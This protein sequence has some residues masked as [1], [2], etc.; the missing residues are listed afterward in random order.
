ME[1]SPHI[2]NRNNRFMKPRQWDSNCR[3]KTV[4]FFLYQLQ[5]NCVVPTPGATHSSTGPD[6]DCQVASALKAHDPPL[7]FDLESDP[8]ENY[9]LS[10]D[11]EPALHGLLDKILEAKAK[12][13]ASMVFGESQ[14]G[15]GSDPALA[16][17][18]APLCQPKPSCCQCW[19]IGKT[20]PK[21]DLNSG[22]P[23]FRLEQGFQTTEL[24]PSPR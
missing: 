18:C 24:S 9:P 16:P 6:P 20:D 7:V 22:F 15:R 21:I 23:C 17:C 1:S 8:S 13:E 5:K 4:L 12:F 2:L 3:L 10:L 11:K 14:V 19:C